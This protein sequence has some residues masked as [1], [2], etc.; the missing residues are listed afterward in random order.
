MTCRD[1]VYDSRIVQLTPATVNIK[2]TG[3]TCSW[4]MWIDYRAN[5]WRNVSLLFFVNISTVNIFTLF[6]ESPFIYSNSENISEN[7][8]QVLP[9]CVFSVDQNMALRLMDVFEYF[10][11]TWLKFHIYRYI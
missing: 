2:Y 11:Y 3:K 5:T 7:V 9:Q 1:I 4:G 8:H 6:Q 10:V